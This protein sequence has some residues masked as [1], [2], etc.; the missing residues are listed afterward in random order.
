MWKRMLGLAGVAA[1]ATT[2]LTSE[3][4]ADVDS[5]PERPIHF[6]IPY[7][8]GGTVDP[9]GRILGAAASEILGQPIVP[10]NR[11]GAAGSV[12]TDIVV[13]SDPDG[14]TVLIH[15]N[16][17]A[18]EPC[19]KPDLP[20][21][22][23]TDMT[24]VM[25]I[26]ETP[27][28]LLVHPS[29]PVETVD[30][31]VEHLKER[32]GELNFGASGVGSS[33]HLRGLQFIVET[34]VEMEYIPYLDGGSTLAGLVSNEIQ[35]AFDTLPGSLGMIQDGR[36]KILAVSTS[37]RWPTVPDVPTMEEA[38]YPGLVSQWIG[39]YVPAATPPEIVNRL[40]EAFREALD[41]PEVQ[42]QYER[43]AFRTIG[44][45]PEETRKLLEDETA[46]WCETIEASGITIE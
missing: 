8:P 13:R 10:E 16:L 12:G 39:A 7:G 19:L 1:L 27:F 5:F 46:M 32:P 15:T 18:S 24:P 22:F 34:G 6:I 43:I 45:G 33:G 40:Y 26:N 36:L 35:L 3:G 29:I 37:E 41:R 38:G 9:T 11:A 20:Y 2:A 30:D 23:R 44:T 42:E 4:V 25:A 28:V 17:V 14:Y 21:D 31:L